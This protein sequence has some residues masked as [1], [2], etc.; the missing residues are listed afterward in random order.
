MC[1]IGSDDAT[2]D[3]HQSDFTSI[4]EKI[5]LSIQASVYAFQQALLTSL[6]VDLEHHRNHHPVLC[7]QCWGPPS[8]SWSGVENCIPLAIRDAEAAVPRAS[9]SSPLNPD[10]LRRY[11]SASG[12]SENDKYSTEY[13]SPVSLWICKRIGTFYVTSCS[14]FRLT[15]Q[16]QIAW[17]YYLTRLEK[18]AF[19]P[20][21]AKLFLL[22]SSTEQGRKPP[23]PSSH[24]PKKP[25]AKTDVTRRVVAKFYVKLTWQRPVTVALLGVLRIWNWVVR[26]SINQSINHNF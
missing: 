9:P 11:L 19:N 20:G 12:P 16:K 22:T 15:T 18:V 17:T 3:Q 23:L 1:F 24:P 6:S 8:L 25:R 2:S 26:K 7:A 4:R 14:G 13:H 5:M 21:T 10:T